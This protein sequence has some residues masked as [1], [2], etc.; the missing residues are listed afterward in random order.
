MFQILTD[1]FLYWNYIHFSDFLTIFF[2]KTFQNELMEIDIFVN[3]FPPN[4]PI[5]C[6]TKRNTPSQPF[7]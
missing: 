3:P 7:T 6:Y 2:L 4:Y 1:N 5:L